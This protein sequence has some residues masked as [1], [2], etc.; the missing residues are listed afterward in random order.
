MAPEV[1]SFYTETAEKDVQDTSC[2]GSGGVPQ[3]QKSPKTGGYRGL[4]KTISAFSPYQDEA[5]VYLYLQKR[6]D[7]S[8]KQET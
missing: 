1:G 7:T 4:I 6:S 8:C 3:L 2:W 5:N